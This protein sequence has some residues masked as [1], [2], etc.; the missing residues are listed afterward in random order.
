LTIDFLTGDDH[1]ENVRLGLRGQHQ[2]TNAL[3]AVALAEA[4]R[5]RGWEISREAI[6][7]GL[8]DAK[9]P[10]RLELWAGRPLLLFDGA[11]N[12]D[13]A[14]ALREYLDRFVQERITMIFGAMRDKRLDE[15]ARLLFPKAHELILTEIDNPRAASIEELRTQLPAERDRSSVHESRAVRN[16]LRIA[17]ELASTAGLIVITGSLYLVGEAQQILQTENSRLPEHKVQH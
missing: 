16:A 8:E 7:Q 17:R 15:M 4:L 11:H 14:R 10:G 13:S 3:V 2:V 6:I 5:E 9:H 1:Y 12:P